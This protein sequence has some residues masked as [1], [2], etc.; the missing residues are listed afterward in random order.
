MKS[1]CKWS[2]RASFTCWGFMRN[3][4]IGTTP[5]QGFKRTCIF[6]YFYSVVC[7]LCMR[8]HFS[9]AS[10]SISL[11]NPG[12]TQV[13]SSGTPKTLSLALLWVGVPSDRTRKRSFGFVLALSYS[14]CHTEPSLRLWFM[15]SA[16]CQLPG[17][18]KLGKTLSRE[19][20]VCGRTM[21][22]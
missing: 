11:S 13:C 8:C 16:F 18:K 22:L 3:E 12:R 6:L 17:L 21:G 1:W 20:K 19:Y 9:P 7:K 10:V 14:I 15:S 2:V 5:K 4:V